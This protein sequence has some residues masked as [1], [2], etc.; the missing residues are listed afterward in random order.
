[1]REQQKYHGRIFCAIRQLKKAF[2]RNATVSVSLCISGSPKSEFP[3]Y[4][5]FSSIVSL[6]LLE[7]KKFSCV[8][9]FMV[10]HTA[11]L[12]DMG[13]EVVSFIAAGMARFS[14]CVF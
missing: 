11:S 1:M 10:P 6:E 5:S 12:H 2:S 3:F 8:C 7:I 9:V 13:Y 4:F 14:R